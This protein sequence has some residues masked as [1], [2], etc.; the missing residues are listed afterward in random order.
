MVNIA[1]GKLTFII[2]KVV[3]VEEHNLSSFGLS[4]R[5]ERNKIWSD[6]CGYFWQVKQEW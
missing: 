4:R 6:R 3:L 1:D 2:E 5:V